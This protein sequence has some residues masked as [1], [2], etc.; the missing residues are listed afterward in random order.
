MELLGLWNL[1]MVRTI[2][3]TLLCTAS[4]CYELLI[5]CFF[6]NFKIWETFITTKFGDIADLS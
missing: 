6:K 3:L 5:M 4:R 1:T 2:S